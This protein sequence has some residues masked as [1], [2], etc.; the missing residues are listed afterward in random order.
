MSSVPLRRNRDFVLLQAGQLLSSLGTQSTVIAY[1][2]LVLALTH[3]ASQ[4]GIVSFARTLPLAL[5]ALPAG[6]VADRIPRKRVMIAADVVR[7]AAL[8]ALTSVVLAHDA[9]YWVVPAVAFAEG[10]GASFFL[11]A[12]PGAMRAVVPKFQLATATSILTARFAIVRLAGPPLGGALFGITRSLPFLADAVSYAF[13]T[14]SLLAMRTPFEEEREPDEARLAHQLSEGLRF[15]WREPLLRTLAFI[16]A[17]ANFILP[18]ITLALVV[19]G[20][21]QGL[22]S[23]EIGGLVAAFGGALFVGSLLAAPVR[24]LLPPRA[25]IV[26][27][28]WTWAGCTLFLA[29]PSVYV[30]AGALIPTGLAIPATDSVVSPYMLSLPPDRLVGRTQAAFATFSQLVIP[31][32]PLAAGFLLADVSARATIAVFAVSGLALAL[33]GTLSPAIRAA[34]ALDRV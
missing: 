24:R 17:L 29:W 33:W 31:L 22:T 16:F 9:S 3:S 26:L 30:L 23:G 32:G 2:L 10:T 25:V 11:A 20:R 27:E 28:L 7:V 13:S 18:G 21:R 5:F 15:L 34:P 14:G 19:V 4:A 8:A 1:P 6:L 12:Q